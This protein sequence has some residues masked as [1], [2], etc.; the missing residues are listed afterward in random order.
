MQA[1]TGADAARLLPSYV[2]GG[3][4]AEH[5]QMRGDAEPQPH[6][7]ALAVYDKAH[8]GGMPS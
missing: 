7:H 4:P 6:G 2:M 1:G 8:R 5:E 3:S